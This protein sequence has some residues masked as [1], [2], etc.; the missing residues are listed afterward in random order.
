VAA[1]YEAVAGIAKITANAHSHLLKTRK[2]EKQTRLALGASTNSGFQRLPSIASNFVAH[3]SEHHRASSWHG[4]AND[5]SVALRGGGGV[6]AVSGVAGRGALRYS[7]AGLYLLLSI[8]L[9]LDA[10]GVCMARSAWRRTGIN[11]QCSR[12]W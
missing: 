4:R 9:C 2:D 6:G 10:L 3:F 12:G 5:A 11:M 7:Y 8:I 1:A